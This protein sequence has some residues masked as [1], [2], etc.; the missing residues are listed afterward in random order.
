MRENEA[1][2]RGT[3]GTPDLWRNTGLLLPEQVSYGPGR[4]RASDLSVRLDFSSN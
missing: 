4:T 1:G 3:R 2:L